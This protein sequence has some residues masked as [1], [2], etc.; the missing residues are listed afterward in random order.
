[1]KLLQCNRRK[2]M[3][4]QYCGCALPTEKEKPEHLIRLNICH[5]K[6]IYEATIKSRPTRWSIKYLVCL[7]E[8]NR[9]RCASMKAAR[10]GQRCRLNPSG[11]LEVKNCTKLLDK[12]R[13]KI[14]TVTS[15][16]LE[17]KNSML[18]FRGRLK[19][20]KQKWKSGRNVYIWLQLNRDC[21]RSHLLH[22]LH[23]K[24]QIYAEN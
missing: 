13:G 6:N 23:A 5:R 15:V 10:S 7:T 8:G 14:K 4:N 20:P 3:F 1:M 17:E 19:F 16:K 18:I 22:V 24:I 11:S 2:S 9:G 21:L 12:Y